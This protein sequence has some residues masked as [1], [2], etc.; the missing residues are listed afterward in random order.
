MAFKRIALLAALLVATVAASPV[1]DQQPSRRLVG[2]FKYP[3][4][5]DDLF[6]TL[7][8]LGLG[9][10]K[11]G[12]IIRE[13]DVTADSGGAV[14]SNQYQRVTQVLYRTTDALGNPDATVAT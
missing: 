10:Y 7:P 5:S 8:L 12:D 4:P 9:S 1:R 13:R 2:G 6:Y 11:P 14:D 3:S